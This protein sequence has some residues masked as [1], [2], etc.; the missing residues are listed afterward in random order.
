MAFYDGNGN[1]KAYD[2]LE[3]EYGR[4]ENTTYY[5]VR[6]PKYTLEGKRIKPI[7]AIT[8]IDGSVDGS[9]SST[10]NYARRKNTWFTINAGLFNMQTVTP[11]GQTIINGVSITNTPMTENNGEAI[12]ELECYPIC[13]DADGVLSAP[14]GRDV[15][16]ATMIADGVKYAVTGWG[17]IVE[18]FQKCDETVFK[19]IVHPGDYIQQ[20]IGQFDNG[21]YCV[22]TVDM[23]RNGKAENDIGM[24]YDEMATML[25]ARG[26]E[27]A[28]ALDGG[29]SC[30]TVI[31][32]R[33]INPIYEG[34]AGRAVPTV[35]YFDVES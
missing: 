13:I 35:I 10:L 14:Y 19:E 33:Q 23:A 3:V 16:T 28:Y 6:I 11:L 1:V 29:G 8:S 21:D 15:D 25:I 17:K 12:T 34:D 9:K 26:V 2:E 30:E 5:L 7:V 31:G 20:C 4:Y 22:L 24:T 27:F 32:K 18:N